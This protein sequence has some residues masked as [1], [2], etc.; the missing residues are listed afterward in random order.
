MSKQKIWERME[1]RTEYRI[2]MYFIEIHGW[3]PDDGD[4]DE[5]IC[6]FM[7]D[8]EEYREWCLNRVA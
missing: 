4:F 2:M 3:T 5:Y 6:E 8:Y 7:D 1:D